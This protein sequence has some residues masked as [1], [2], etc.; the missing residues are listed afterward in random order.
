MSLNYNIGP[1]LGAEIS[2]RQER[3]ADAARGTR[4][5]RRLRTRRAAGLAGV[6]ASARRRFGAAH[7][8]H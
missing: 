6:R 8:A 5:V 4:R 2:Y 3:I 1:A 7:L